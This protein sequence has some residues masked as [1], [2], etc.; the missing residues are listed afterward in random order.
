MCEEAC[1][2]D[3]I[4]LTTIYD[5]TGESREEMLFDRE[6]LLS[7]Y[8]KTTAAGTDPVRTHRGVLGPASDVVLQPDKH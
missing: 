7:I 5:L 2:V 6:K 1:P 3:A 4:E 8:D